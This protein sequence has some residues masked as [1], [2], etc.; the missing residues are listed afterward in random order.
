[1]RRSR[2]RWVLLGLLALSAG[3][4]FARLGTPGLFDADE[5]AYAQAAREML[6]SGDWVTPR[7]NGQPRFD[8][9]VLFY[10][11]IVLAYRVFGIGEFA[12]R[13]WSALAGVGLVLVLAG[14]ARRRFGPPA[15]LW[16]GLVFATTLLTALLARAAV[17]DMLL[18][19]FVAGAVL[20]GLE[21]LGAPTPQAARRPALLG[22]GAAALAVLV[23]GPIGLLVP[24]LALV[25]ALWILRELAA[26]RRLVPWQGPLLLAALAGPWYAL[27]LGANGWA[28][29]EGFVLKHHVTRYVGVVSSHAGPLWFY[30]PVLLVGFFPWSGYLPRALWRAWRVARARQAATPGDRLLLVS[31]CWAVGLLLFF[32][33]AGTKLPSYL[34]PAFPALALLVGND[35]ARAGREAGSRG[36]GEAGKRP[37]PASAAPVAPP[38]WLARLGAWLIGVTGIGLAAALAALPLLLDRLRPLSR[39]VLDGAVVS[40][41][42]PI[43]LAAWLLLGTLL[44]LGRR[45]PARSAILAGTMVG[46]ILAAGLLVGP[47]AYAVVQA[48]LREFALAA[49][50]ALPA[51]EP[52]VVYGLNAPTIVFYADRRVLPLGPGD[53]AAIPR[54][55]GMVRSGRPVAVI[56]R[57][58]HAPA[59]ESIPGL[60]RRASRGG[61]AFF[62]SR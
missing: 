16:T 27:A 18:T 25:P 11:L 42:L 14:A 15:D 23:K 24:A 43:G 56:T 4:F 40:P 34:F 22:W 39:G 7:F 46:L 41:A 51:G 6:E 54:I 32:S 35:L 30:L 61:Y 52:V 8:K 1:M 10:W 36:A 9:P 59:L 20:L 3:L 62:S 13:C 31:A 19:L 49:R 5:P 38:G 26:W 50:H 29:V 17:T 57:Q 12:V 47:Q 21:A 2:D 60:S 37:A 28:F 58:V 33:L 53:P 48:P 45:G 44:A 55:E